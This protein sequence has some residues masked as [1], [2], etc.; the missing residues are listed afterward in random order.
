MFFSA[1][2]HPP[3]PLE[4]SLPRIVLSLAGGAWD[5][6][7]RGWQGELRKGGRQ[8]KDSASLPRQINTEILIIANSYYALYCQNHLI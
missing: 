2:F 1:M 8:V 7:G 5:V 6:D 3:H 4:D